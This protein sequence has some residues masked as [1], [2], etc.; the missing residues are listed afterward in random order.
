MVGGHHLE[1]FSDATD[2]E[3]KNPVVATVDGLIAR[4]NGTHWVAN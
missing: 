4:W 1:F 3:S 2:P